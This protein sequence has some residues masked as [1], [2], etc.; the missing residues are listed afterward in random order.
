MIRA[1]RSS[2]SR[3]AAIWRIGTGAEVA[4]ITNGISPGRTITAA[5][6][7]VFEAYATVVLPDSDDDQQRHDLAVS[8]VLNE[9][10]ASQSGGS[11]I[12]TPAPMHRLPRCA[13]GDFHS[14]W[15]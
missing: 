5:I 2:G 14:G 10:P 11:D 7:P 4:W 8:A 12:S 9:Q 6:P 13:H 3:T 1:R 15:H